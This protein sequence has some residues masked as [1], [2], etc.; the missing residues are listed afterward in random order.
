ME[1]GAGIAG[2][3]FAVVMFDDSSVL[4]DNDLVAAI[5]GHQMMSNDDDCAALYQ[6]DQG[7]FNELLRAPVEP[8]R[9]F[10]EDYD[11]RVF[12]E[13]TGEG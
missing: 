6:L 9:C 5:E 10:I 7:A 12:Q 3:T 2:K 4:E 11:A 1:A 13:D 8:G